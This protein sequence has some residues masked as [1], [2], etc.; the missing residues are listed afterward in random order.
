[1]NDT[2]FHCPPESA[3]EKSLHVAPGRSPRHLALRAAARRI[4]IEDTLRNFLWLVNASDEL[5][6]L[7]RI[8]ANLKAILEVFDYQLGCEA[9]PEDSSAIFRGW[10]ELLAWIEGEW[11]AWDDS[12]DRGGNPNKDSVF[13]RN[14]MFACLWERREDKSV[15]IYRALQGH[16]LWAHAHYLYKESLHNP[17]AGCKGYE[18]YDGDIL[19]G[20]VPSA[21][22][23]A[24]RTVRYLAEHQ[25]GPLIETLPNATSPPDFARIIGKIECPENVE[26]EWRAT[27][28]RRREVLRSFL[29]KANG[30]EPWQECDRSSTGRPSPRRQ[31]AIR[32]V[33]ATP[34]DDEDPDARWPSARMVTIS[35][36]TCNLTQDEI[37]ELDLDEEEIG[38]QESRYLVQQKQQ[39]QNAQQLAIG[40]ALVARGQ[41]RHVQMT[42]QLLPWSY[43]QLTA[44]E[45]ADLLK[46][47]NDELE[48]LQ[49]PEQLDDDQQLS[50]ELMALIHTMLWTG[51]SIERARNLKVL[52]GVETP[53]LRKAR[54]RD[55]LLLFD[56][57]GGEWHI[58]SIR[59]PYRSEIP[60]PKKQA[61]V[62]ARSFS[63]PDVSHA[64]EFL[65][66]VLA[67][68]L[69]F[70]PRDSGNVVQATLPI[71]GFGLDDT[72]VGRI[73]QG[74]LFARD[75]EDYSDA[76]KNWLKKNDPTSRVTAN[77]IG[78]FLFGRIVAAT[79]DLMAA[80]SVTGREH[81]QARTQQYYSA[82]SVAEL[83]EIYVKAT[84]AVASPPSTA[85]APVRGTVPRRRVKGQGEYVGARLCAS[86]V[87]VRRAIA[88]LEK[89]IAKTQPILDRSGSIA[90]HNLFTLHTVLLF[91]FATSMRAIR[92][93]Y[94]GP[95]RIDTDTGF[96]LI[97]D[98]DD[99]ARHK[100]RLAWVPPFVIN[101][102]L[103]YAEHV[104][105]LSSDNLKVLNWPEPC[106]FLQED[107]TPEEVRPKTLKDYMRPF[108]DLPPNL[109]RRFMRHELLAGGCPP[110]VV[111][112]WLGH[113]FQGEEPWGP[114]SSLKYAEYR[115]SLR[116]PLEH[117]LKEE[118]EW[119]TLESPL[120]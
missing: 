62:L 111:N 48:R 60:D 17:L 81:S 61:H 90:F 41:L 45:L 67:R 22:D 38:D 57:V 33:D 93:P 37:L 5:L 11:P 28:P 118:L 71:P 14:P 79:G 4:G 104:A 24:A 94:L 85:A 13:I 115:E 72:T 96:T 103:L 119:K 98:K 53:A 46:R 102:M 108:L 83:Q 91:S 10:P 80:V 88:L 29:A 21:L 95:E 110:E 12:G 15:S 9:S 6:G 99:D 106:F 31:L 114:F 69:C 25:W 120:V 65:K 36:T 75:V 63:L 70:W 113:A 43:N 50:A 27:W 7:R 97:S 112:A 16:L 23:D 86:K 19:W 59:P 56:L 77:R 32:S 49:K 101:Q 1:M 8:V 35:E 55:S 44:Q 74:Y 52:T 20:I 3:G 51:S 34:G 82:Y 18:M 105:A 2:Q 78:T 76:L 26:Q 117:I 64:D 100:T 89:R 107:G 66:L 109:H 42:N 39:S 58:E 87:S 92:T 30:I 54:I 40:A 68:H 84:S 73:A 47:S 116:G